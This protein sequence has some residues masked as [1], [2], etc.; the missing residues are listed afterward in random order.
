MFL[1]WKGSIRVLD[2]KIDVLNYS[3]YFTADESLTPAIFNALTSP[4]SPASL[5]GVPADFL[6]DTYRK[7][8]FDYEVSGFIPVGITLPQYQ[9]EIVLCANGVPV[10]V[11]E[12]YKQFDVEQVKKVKSW[13]YTGALYEG[14]YMDAAEIP[15][16]TGA[17]VPDQPKSVELKPAAV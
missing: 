13:I 7:A 12:L 11:S 2:P 1:A 17:Y 16:G 6:N 5:R 3:K 15:D 4:L 9:N 8:L 14:K 10:Q